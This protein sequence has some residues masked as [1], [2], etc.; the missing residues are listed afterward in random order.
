[1]NKNAVLNPEQRSA[2][3]EAN[4]SRLAV[5]PEKRQASN[6]QKSYSK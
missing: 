6:E 3:A 1:M 2:I 4:K 5:I